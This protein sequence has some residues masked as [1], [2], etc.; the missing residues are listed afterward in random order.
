M[1]DVLITPSSGNI[2][3]SQ[4]ISDNA[5]SVALSGN[6]LV[7]S[8]AS[9]NISISS[10]SGLLINGVAVSASGHTHTSANITDFNSS[11][12]G[13]INGIYAPLN[14]PTLTGVPLAPTA[15]SGTNTNQIASTAFVRTEISNLVASAPSTLDT[16]NELATALGNDA[17]FSTTVTN[18]LAGKANLSGASFTGSITSPSGNFTQSL[19]VNGTGVSLSGHT[20]T[21]FEAT[22][23]DVSTT[24][25]N[26]KSQGSQIPLGFVDATDATQ[27]YVK[28]DNGGNLAFGAQAAIV[29]EAGGFGYQYEVAKFGS[30]G[31]VGI[32]VD[33]PVY[34]LDVAGTGNFR[35][36]MAVGSIIPENIYNAINPGSTTTN[37]LIVNGYVSPAPTDEPPTIDL[38][39]TN[40][41]YCRL[42]AS[43][44]M[45]TNSTFT[46]PDNG[47]GVIGLEVH[48]HGNI[49]S[50]GTIGASGNKVLITDVDGVITTTDYAPKSQ[51]L[52]D[53]VNNWDILSF[54][55]ATPVWGTEAIL[56]DVH[57]QLRDSI[58]ASPLVHSHGNINSSGQIGSVANRVITTSDSGLLVA[59]SD[60]Q[61]ECSS[62]FIGISGDYIANG[63]MVLAPEAIIFSDNTV[64]E[65]AY[66]GKIGSTSGLLVVTTTGGSLTSSSGINSS[67]ISNFNSSVSG[68]L[69]VKNI[70]AGSGIS[71]NNNSGIFTINSSGISNINISGVSGIIVSSSGNNYTIGI[72]IIDCGVIV[73]SG[74]SLTTPLA[75]YPFDSN[76]NSTNPSY[77]GTAFGSPSFVTGRVNNAIQLNTGAK[78]VTIPRSISTNWTIAFFV[79]TSSSSP[80]Y[81]NWYD[82]VSLVNGEAPGSVNDFGITYLNNKVAF[83]V[84]NPD[85]TLLSNSLINTG[86]WKHVTCTRNSSTG[87]MKIY[88]DGIFETSMTGPT[89][90]KTAFTS[91]VI[92]GSVKYGSFNGLIDNLKIYDSILTDSEISLL[93]G[94]S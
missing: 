79:N 76:V 73:P 7:L 27:C 64:Q 33:S 23:N 53:P 93:A 60:V 48:S 87:Q 16:L 40:G 75:A 39:A 25:L 68:L 57:I 92:G 81:S 31:N 15:S 9:G 43:P 89:G 36:I 29:F 8:S 58:F 54:S 77:N 46:F 19:L 52:Y 65:T 56:N 34:K 22:S 3:F 10:S 41:N 13:L 84:G 42:V 63:G 80:S 49:T 90:A 17:N 20:H 59:N 94:G 6:S 91:F 50:S 1:P 51:I 44:Y 24:I 55:D 4:N 14:S 71:I 12:S 45:T 67:L 82:G 66:T 72:G 5:A 88:I 30:D 28:G 69:A 47:G 83:G 61:F 85:T 74:P 18:S 62:I 78:Y 26:I 35:D 11:V 37:K 70:T 21:V 38:N 86:T 2:R 32:G